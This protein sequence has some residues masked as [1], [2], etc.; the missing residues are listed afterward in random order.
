MSESN[1][2]L[3]IVIPL[4]NEEE[5]LEPLHEKIRQVI[6]QHEYQ[7]T[8]FFV[9]DGS[10]DNSYE[11]IQRLADKDPSVSALRFRRN[12]GKS[13]ALEAAFREVASDVVI[14]M[15]ADLQDD[16]EEIP[17]LLAKLDEG[18]DLV[19]G[20]KRKRHDPITKTVPSKLFNWVTV[21]ASGL[22]IHDFN[23][24]LKAYRHDVVEELRVA[25]G[26]HRYLPALAHWRGFR[27]GEIPVRHHPRIHG[28]TKFGAARLVNGFLDLLTVLLMTRYG[29]RPMHLFGWVG[30]FISMAGFAICGYIGFLRLVHGW[31]MNR[32]P[33]L[34]LGVLLILLGTQILATGL[35]ADVI[36]SGRGHQSD[37][38]IVDRLRVGSSSEPDAGTSTL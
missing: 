9:D 19:S 38:A 32:Y 2:T 8:I 5:S 21:R 24:G 18:F 4:L 33:L 1:L 3:T 30:T 37:F 16:P 12:F 36:V 17:N 10:T 13:A 22:D 6:D 35:L 26:M 20:W 25:R 29:G 15:D 7:V 11:V 28:T 23:C 31:I 34:F 27:V 14:T